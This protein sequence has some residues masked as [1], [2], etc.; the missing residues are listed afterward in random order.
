MSP[1]NLEE[2]QRDIEEKIVLEN[3]AKANTALK[4][5]RLN[6]RILPLPPAIRENILSKNIKNHTFYFSDKWG[7]G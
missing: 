4:V 3:R 6:E 7:V 1:Q 2:E 5:S